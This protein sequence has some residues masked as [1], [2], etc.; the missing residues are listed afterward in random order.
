MQILDIRDG[1]LAIY[2]G[3]IGG[4]VTIILYCKKYE[5]NLFNLLD[6]LAPA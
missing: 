3:I 2:G 6:Y 1:G 5:I 4:I